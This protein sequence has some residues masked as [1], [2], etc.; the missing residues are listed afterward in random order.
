MAR[1]TQL[2]QLLHDLRAEIGAST[3]V[4]AGVDMAENLKTALRRNQELLY[5]GHDWPHLRHEVSKSLSA[6]QRYYDM[7]SGMNFDRIEVVALEYGSSF[8]M[9]RRGVGFE[10]YSVHNP[11]NDERSSPAI[12]W[13][14]KFTGSTDQIEVW[15]L[16]DST[17]QTLWFQGIRNLRALSADSDTAM[18]DDR[19]IV[20][21]TAAEYLARKKSGDANSKLAAAKER[22]DTVKANA[23][24]GTTTIRMGLGPSN[25]DT[26]SP[27]V[28]RVN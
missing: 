2:S 18:L 14:V 28:V 4:S 27:T 19:L 3:L 23:Q 5:D 8:R 9:L 16:P 15:P 10:Q 6:G 24:A 11:M 17:T 1:G 13:D 7:P 20:L 21:Y 22:L 12:R 26:W 25:E